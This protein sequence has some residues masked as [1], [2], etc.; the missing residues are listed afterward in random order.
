MAGIVANLASC[1][2]HPLENVKIR[3]QGKEEEKI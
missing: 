2:F 1:I 3:F